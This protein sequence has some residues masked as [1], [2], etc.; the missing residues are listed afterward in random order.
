VG[1]SDSSPAKAAGPDIARLK[2]LAL[3]IQTRG[4]HAFGLAWLGDDGAIQ[5][6]KQPG[7]AQ[8][9]L[10]ELDRCRHA[11]VM[12][13]HCRYATHGSPADNRNNHP[14]AAGTGWLVHNGVV[15]N[16]EAIV[17]RYSL[18][19][20]GECDSEALGLLIARCPGSLVDRSAWAMSQATGDMAMLGIWRKPARLLVSRRGR[21]LHSGLARD[22]YYFASL[23]DGL[24]GAVRQVPDRSIRVLTYRD[25]R[26]DLEGKRVALT[27]SE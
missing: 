2:R 18:R 8:T 11:V 17:R 4:M 14:H 9:H 22:G 6:F 1:F 5:T 20:R 16:H 13:G 7:A 24:P 3:I 10:D 19:Q 23:P 21:P 12:V 15:L 26:L 25:G 27:D